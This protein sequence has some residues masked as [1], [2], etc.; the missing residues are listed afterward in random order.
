MLAVA[1]GWRKGMDRRLVKDL[2]LTSR[3]VEDHLKGNRLYLS[4]PAA[5]GQH[6]KLSWR[7]TSTGRRWGKRMRATW[8]A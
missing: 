4:M 5:A 7:P 2:P 6:L 8:R 3:V 1:G